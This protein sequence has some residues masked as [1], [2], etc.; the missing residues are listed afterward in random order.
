[1]R[2]I[3]KSALITALILVGGLLLLAASSPTKWSLT[4]VMGPTGTRLV[5]P[6]S[7]TGTVA[8]TTSTGAVTLSNAAVFTTSASFQCMAVNMTATA[9]GV[10]VTKASGTSIQFI[11]AGA[12]DTVSYVCIGN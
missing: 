2:T 12:T 4:G 9:G 5:L 1:M 3:L 11:T 7:V 10:K 8:A 6:H